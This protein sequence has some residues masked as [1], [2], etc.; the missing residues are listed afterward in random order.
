[1]NTRCNTSG[2]PLSLCRAKEAFLREA[3]KGFD[4]GNY[5]FRYANGAAFLPLENRSAGIIR[6]VAGPDP[7]DPEFTAIQVDIERDGTVYHSE[8]VEFA[9]AY[10]MAL[11]KEEKGVLQR[12]DLIVLPQ[13]DEKAAVPVRLVLGCLGD[14]LDKETPFFSTE[15]VL[16]ASVCMKPA[17]DLL[18]IWGEIF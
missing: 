8:Q 10:P 7:D 2:E 5:G 12:Q 4:T 14:P 11:R 15:G 3:L 13:Y 6:L 9:D 1:M 18:R 17:M 16:P